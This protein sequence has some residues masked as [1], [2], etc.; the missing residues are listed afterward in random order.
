MA[1]KKTIRTIPQERTPMPEQDPAER[2]RNF[3]EVAIGYTV[4]NA[5]REALAN[6]IKHGNKHVRGI[7]CSRLVLAR[8]RVS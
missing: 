8:K 7:Y 6:A 2:A 1:K 4:E 5:L 3:K